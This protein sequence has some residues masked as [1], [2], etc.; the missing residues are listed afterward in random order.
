MLNHRINAHHLRTLEE[1]GKHAFPSSP[2]E[3]LQSLI[4][5]E[6]PALG[7]KKQSKGLSVEFCELLISLW[8]KCMEEK[9][10]R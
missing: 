5:G 9:Y 7:L 2:K 6:I 10:V 1:L 8:A 3:S 4:L